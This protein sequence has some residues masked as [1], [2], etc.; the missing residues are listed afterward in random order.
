MAKDLV[1]MK[2]DLK[3]LYYKIAIK[4]KIRV[5]VI[6]NNVINKSKK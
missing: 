6:N 4:H 2:K 5:H 1:E 3:L